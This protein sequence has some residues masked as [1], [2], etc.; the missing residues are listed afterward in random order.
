[1]ASSSK[2]RI[3]S[4][5]IG[6]LQPSAAAVRGESD[7]SEAPR[8][9]TAG[10]GRSARSRWSA[11][12]VA[13][14]ASG[15]LLPS[16]A[17]GWTISTCRASWRDHPA[18]RRRPGRA[19]HARA[20]ARFGRGG[21][22]HPAVG[23]GDADRRPVAGASQLGLRACRARRRGP[24]APPLP[25]GSDV[26]GRHR[27]DGR[28][29]PAR[30]R[31]RTVLRLRCS[32]STPSRAGCRTQAVAWS[33]GTLA[34]L[35]LVSTLNNPLGRFGG[36]VV[37]SA[38]PRRRPSTSRAWPPTTA[39]RCLPRSASG[40]ATRP[41]ARSTPSG[42]GSPASC[43]MSVAHTMATINVQARVA[44][45]VL[46]RQPDQAAE[47]MRAIKAGKQGG[48]ARLRADP[49]TS[50][51]GSTRDGDGWRPLPAWTSSTGWSSATGRPGCR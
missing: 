30:L 40:R 9:T 11:R 32:P 17:A 25:P 13:R 16:Y 12:G 45:H 1:M 36:G 46:D 34:V 2:G 10:G 22:P 27:R 49:R 48:P 51:A 7:R 44:A 43:T 28:V 18:A 20:P 21:P 37:L 33:L 42:C 24:R 41:A 26:A 38:G 14:G 23:H 5:R 6:T 29:Q 4:G 50:C 8:A 47:A 31:Q 39:A 19:R 35:T 15:R 3:G